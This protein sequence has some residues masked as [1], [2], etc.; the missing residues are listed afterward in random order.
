ME[1]LPA[2]KKKIKKTS[3][4]KIQKGMKSIGNGGYICFLLP[5]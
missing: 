2:I 1:V 3:E 5:M 4:G